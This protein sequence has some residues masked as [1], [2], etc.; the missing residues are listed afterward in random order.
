VVGRTPSASKEASQ[1]FSTFL[2]GSNPDPKKFVE[3]FHDFAVF[4]YLGLVGGAPDE[5]RGDRSAQTTHLQE[6]CEVELA[7]LEPATSW[8]R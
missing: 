8:V 5:I 1:K 4:R 6:L 2:T 7:G 3:E